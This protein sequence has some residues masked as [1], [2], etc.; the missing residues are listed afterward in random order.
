MD[1]ANFAPAPREMP[2]AG[3]CNAAGSFKPCLYFKPNHNLI[4]T[5]VPCISHVIN[6]YN[7]QYMARIVTCTCEYIYIYMWIY[8]HIYIIII[9]CWASFYGKVGH[10]VARNLLEP[11]SNHLPV[12]KWLLPALPAFLAAAAW[13]AW[14][15]LWLGQPGGAVSGTRKT[16]KRRR[17]LLNSHFIII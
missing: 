2:V 3:R 1:N 8:I 15:R 16:W 12:A 4:P 11:P 13:V 14:A 17:Y 9:Y 10:L 5:V 7:I 6:Y